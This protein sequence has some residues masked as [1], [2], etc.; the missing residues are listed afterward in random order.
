MCGK[1]FEK[2]IFNKTF[3]CFI[4]NG[5]ISPNH[6]GFKPGDSCIDQLLSTTHD[7]YKPFECN[8][9]VRCVFLDISKAFDKVWHDGI[10]FKLAQNDILEISHTFT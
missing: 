4:E 9:E 6:P 10:I 1:I 3:K 7:I 5:L 8:Y 2:L